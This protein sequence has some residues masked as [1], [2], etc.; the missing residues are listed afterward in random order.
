MHKRIKNPL[1]E[2]RAQLLLSLKLIQYLLLY[3]IFLIVIISFP[4]ILRFTVE[5]YP[6]Q[7]QLAASREF[8][9]LHQRVV[10]AILLVML[11]ESFHFLY[12]THRKVYSRRCIQ[13]KIF[14]LLRRV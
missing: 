3:T 7:E 13:G 10:P 9:F 1:V 12:I 11:I 6:V 14:L 2:K 4:S 5:E 8:I